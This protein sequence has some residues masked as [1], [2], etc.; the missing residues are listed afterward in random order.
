MFPLFKTD[1][2]VVRE[3]SKIDYIV[4]GTGGLDINFDLHEEFE[5]LT[6]SEKTLVC[7]KNIYLELKEWIND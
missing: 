2:K 6:Q 4:Y 1:C 7:K 5:K 3:D